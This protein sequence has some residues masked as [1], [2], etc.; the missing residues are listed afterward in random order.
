MRAAVYTFLHSHNVCDTVHTELSDLPL[1]CNRKINAAKDFLERR[2]FLRTIPFRLLE[3]EIWIR[4]RQTHMFN[5]I[6]SNE[7]NAATGST[8]EHFA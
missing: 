3:Q 8:V 7:R 1:F 4:K 2:L 5:V 6:I